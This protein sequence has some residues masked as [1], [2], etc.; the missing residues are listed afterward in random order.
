MTI[1]ATTLS[2]TTDTSSLTS[3]SSSS[4]LD[5]DD[6]LTLLMAQLQYQD[7][8]NPVDNTEMVSQ[9]SQF[10]SLEQL[11]NINTSLSGMTSLLSTYGQANAVNYLGADVTAE[12]DTISKSGTTVSSATYTLDDAATAVTA[13]VYDANGSIVA[14]VN[15]GSQTSG[16]HTFQWDGTN[17]LGASTAN[18]TYTVSFNATDSS[19]SSLDVTSQVSGT[20][21]GISQSDSTTYLTLSDGRSVSLANVSSVTKNASS[22]TTTS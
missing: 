22:S 16:S 12:G 3:S 10:S 8:L 2:S 4:S 6:F 17:Y 20:V 18:G 13:N 1:T 19:G 21:T 9:L 5:Q 14:S 11:T 15:L 7:P